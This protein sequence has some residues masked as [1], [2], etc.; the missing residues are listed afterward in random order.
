MEL[1]AIDINADAGESFGRW[2]LGR[3]AELLPLVTTVN[4]ACGFHAGD[5]AAMRR[6]LILARGLGLSIGA[7]PGYPDLLGFGR[8]RLA[9]STE[10]A[11]D[12]IVYQ[13]GALHGLALTEGI[14]LSH[15][16]PHGA[17]YG[18]VAES[19]ELALGVA[20]QLQ[21]IRPGLALLI[22]PGAGAKAVRE[23]GLPV[24][25]DAA[26]DLEYD[27]S[28]WNI[29]EPVPGE[30]DPAAVAEQAA[31]LARGH[32][33]TLSGKRVPLAAESLCVHGDRPNAP[34]IAREVR[35]RLEEDGIDI[36]SAFSR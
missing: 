16:K 32:V 2:V 24:V 1:T 6:S 9:T 7:H 22:A 8:R 21:S 3:D 17:L 14:E 12:Y 34:Q 10:E 15:V 29:I 30:K 31:G 33:T 20:R 18:Q 28:G 23:A 5:P 27:D 11:L 36:R 4:I 13:T 35:A 25:L 19:A 26:A